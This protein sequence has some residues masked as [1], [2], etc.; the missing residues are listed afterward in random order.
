ML[1]DL[2]DV[3]DIDAVRDALSRLVSD[4]DW[5]NEIAKVEKGAA[6]YCEDK[7][8]GSEDTTGQRV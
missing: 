8:H 3:K 2:F 7:V 5:I 4:F 6:E 1:T